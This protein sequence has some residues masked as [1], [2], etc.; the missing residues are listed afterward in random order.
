MSKKSDKFLELYRTY[1]TVLREQ[2]LDYKTVEDEA[3][4]TLQ[5]RLRITRQMRNYFTHCQDAGFLDVS[6]LQIKVLEQWIREQKMQGDVLRK[7][8]KTIRM[9]VCSTQDKCVDV[10][11]KMAKLGAQEMPVM[12]DNLFVGVVDFYKLVQTYVDGT[13]AMK[14]DKVPLCKKGCPI[15]T[16]DT[17]MD[18]VFQ[19]RELHKCVCC[20]DDGTMS[21]KPLGVYFF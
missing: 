8:C 17:S 10:I 15:L 13:K 20:T 9:G 19:Y 21:G 18:K 3:E 7:Q 16:P 14:M 6:D 12:K 2:G 1:E 11:K 5:N 4:D